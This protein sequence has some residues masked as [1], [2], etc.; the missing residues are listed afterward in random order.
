MN[1]LAVALGGAF[2]A[3]ARYGIFLWFAPQPGRFPVATY[4]ANISG[5]FIAGSLYVL[6]AQAI[7]PQAWRPLLAIGFLGA[8]TT[9]SAFSLEALLLWQNQ[10][11]SLATLYIVSTVLGCLLAV[12]LG[13]FCTHFFLSQ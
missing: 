8:F 7:V 3:M 6:M 12:W 4:F 9:F 2:G 13:H 11:F 10:H 1:W 5:C